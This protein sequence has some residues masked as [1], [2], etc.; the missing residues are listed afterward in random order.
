[1]SDRKRWA[2]GLRGS[3]GK[4]RRGRRGVVEEDAFLLPVPSRSPVYKTPDKADF[5][6]RDDDGDELLTPAHKQVKLLSREEQVDAIIED[7]DLS[8][9]LFGRDFEVVGRARPRRCHWFG[10]C[11]GR[12]ACRSE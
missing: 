6:E 9:A 8:K 11:W 4:R 12:S 7:T 5:V 1:M 3:G 10:D 2:R